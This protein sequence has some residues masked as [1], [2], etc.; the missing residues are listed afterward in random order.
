MPPYQSIGK[1]RLPEE[2]AKMIADTAHMVQMHPKRARLDD[3]AYW[4]SLAHEP[5]E[6][7]DGGVCEDVAGY[8]FMLFTVLG[9]TE[10]S[11]LR[12]AAR[13]MPS[14]SVTDTTKFLKSIQ[15]VLEVGPF[16]IGVNR[17]NNFI[18]QTPEIHIAVQLLAAPPHMRKAAYTKVTED[19]I[20]IP[21]VFTY[22]AYG[23]G[24]FHQWRCPLDESQMCDWIT[25]SLRHIREAVEV[26]TS[27]L[28]ME[29]FFHSCPCDGAV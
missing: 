20:R 25:P 28:E 4:C 13:E 11:N 24:T 29:E 5:F 8:A 18:L 2:N 26:K 12:T 14:A 27:K 6:Y 1:K 19:C 3:F 9:K 21:M 17:P 10:D 15:S 16:G 7:L 22:N 23:N